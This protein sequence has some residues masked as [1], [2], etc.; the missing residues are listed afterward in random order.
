MDDQDDGE[1][2]SGPVA[3][4]RVSVAS[5]AGIGLMVGSM[6]GLAASPTVATFIGAIGAV[7]AAL[8]GLNDR[9]FSAA[10]GLR[11]GAFGV[12]AAL[13]ACLGLYAQKHGVLAPNLSAQKAQLVAAGYSECQAL[14]LLS[15]R[16]LRLQAPDPDADLEALKAQYVALGFSECQA[17]AMLT[18]GADGGAA[19]GAGRTPGA[20]E[21]L[22]SLDGSRTRTSSAVYTTRSAAA[23]PL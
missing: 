20:R 11:I 7:L 19:G 2:P 8:L 3:S 16:S 6:L 18:G 15:G 12:F 23:R 4:R 10:K 5:G 17:L 1:A 9:H 21:M 22:S 13:G 14:D